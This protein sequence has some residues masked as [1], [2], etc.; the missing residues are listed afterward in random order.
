MRPKAACD[1]MNALEL[2]SSDCV[3][4]VGCGSGYLVAHLFAAGAGEV[5]ALAFP[6]VLEAFVCSVP[7][8]HARLTLVAEDFMHLADD[9]FEGISVIT[10]LIGTNDVVARLLHVFAQT[11]C[12]RVVA[13][14]RPL[15]G[16]DEM[17]RHSGLGAPRVAVNLTQI[18]L[19]GSGEKRIA[20]VLRKTAEGR[21]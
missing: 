9:A 17:L 20:V 7:G 16:F 14:M 4:E 1:L 15:R 3:M 10:Q 19:A 8:A 12:V 5:E 21:P 2:T 11:A 18:A 13:F 6:Q